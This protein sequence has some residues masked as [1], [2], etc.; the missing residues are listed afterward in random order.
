MITDVNWIKRMLSH[1]MRMP[2]PVTPGYGKLL[3]QG[4][5]TPAE[6][7]EVIENICESYRPFFS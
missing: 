3:K 4:L 6:L 5:L 2:M 7:E 1:N